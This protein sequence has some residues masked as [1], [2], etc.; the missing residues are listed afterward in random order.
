MLRCITT[1]T[2][3]E[4]M[5]RR[6]QLSPYLWATRSSQALCTQPET[7]QCVVCL[8]QTGAWAE[9]KSLQQ[10]GHQVLCLCYQTQNVDAINKQEGEKK[11]R[12]MWG[13]WVELFRGNQDP[14]FAWLEKDERKYEMK[15][16]SSVYK[17]QRG[18][19]LQISPCLKL[20]TFT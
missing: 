10:I 15:N 1:H 18:P 3:I 9:S 5:K 14:L 2:K 20:S 11:K 4:G 6:E 13:T 17:G 19:P 16:V 12:G 7:A 8:P